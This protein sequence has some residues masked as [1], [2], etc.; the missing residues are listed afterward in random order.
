[1]AIG[2]RWTVR[3]RS[4]MAPLLAMTRGTP[5][6]P[7]VDVSPDPVLEIRREQILTT[8]QK[9]TIA[10][11]GSVPSSV[12]TLAAP[13]SDQ[14][15]RIERYTIFTSSFVNLFGFQISAGTP[16]ADSALVDAASS[17]TQIVVTV[18]E[19]NGIWLP[20]GTPLHFVW[21]GSSAEHFVNVQYRVEEV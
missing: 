12:A 17:W 9:V 8:P 7:V 18:D 20:P 6:Q 5:P 21:L 14:S 1:M 4:G 11:V 13:P 3:P 16:G 15:Y 2:N 19:N 10:G